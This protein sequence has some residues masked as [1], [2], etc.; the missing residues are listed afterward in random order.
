MDVLPALAGALLDHWSL[1]PDGLAMHG[2]CALVVPVRTEPGEA[3]V[4]KVAFPDEES[5]HEHLALQHWGGRGAVRLHACRPASRRDA[6]RAAASGTADRGLGPRGLRGRGGPLRAP[7]RAGTPAAA[8]THDL[9][10]ALDRPS[11]TA[12]PGG[13]PCRAGWSSRPSRWAGTS[14]LMLTAP[15]R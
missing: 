12:C 13:R 8:T 9:R 10:R 3:A 1:T 11:S 14:S 2:A 6:A 5:E 15:A 4:L 7:A